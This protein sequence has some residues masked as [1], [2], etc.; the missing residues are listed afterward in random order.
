MRPFFTLGFL[1]VLNICLLAQPTIVA[2]GAT[3]LPGDAVLFQTGDG[4]T[5]PANWNGGL[6]D[7]AS[8]VSLSS[9]TT[10]YDD[11][12]TTTNGASYPTATV[13]EEYPFGGWAYYKDSPGALDILGYVSFFGDL[14]CSAD[15]RYFKYPFTYGQ[16]ETTSVQCTGHD[17]GTPFNR[18]GQVVLSGDG[19]GS[20]VL[21]YGTI[22]NVLRIKRTSELH[23]L[24][25]DINNNSLTHE[26]YYFKPGLRFPLL[27]VVDDV[28]NGNPSGFSQML[29]QSMVGIEEALANSIGM[30]L[31]PVP[32]SG[33]VN[34]RFGAY[35][36]IRAEVLDDMG[37]VV[38]T[39][40]LG[41]Q[42]P[43]IHEA[44]IGLT[45]L[46]TGLYSVHLSDD[47]GGNGTLRMMVK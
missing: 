11:P 36:N 24:G 45:G 46:A 4:F 17:F 8:Y 47:H 22:G 28:T 14:S 7:H 3:P 38:R 25:T 9:I 30:E 2:G 31:Y 37:R 42:A 10:T 5:P 39:S 6:E 29:D 1:S 32:A 33:S 20:L 26:Y 44:A 41:D 43:G 27:I 16:T 19:Y 18:T 34:V 35:G 12:A 13:A 15:Y 21:P 23:E 40:D